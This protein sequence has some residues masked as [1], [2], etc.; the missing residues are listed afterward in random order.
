VLEVGKQIQKV[1]NALLTI[2]E[3]WEP[4][5]RAQFAR[6][7]MDQVL[8]AVLFPADARL[9][10]QMFV[11]TNLYGKRLDQLALLKGMIGDLAETQEQADAVVV[12][13]TSIQDRLGR[14]FESFMRAIDV[15]ERVELNARGGVEPQQDNWCVELGTHLE[16]HY[17]QGKIV[18]WMEWLRDY[19]Y[20]WDDLQ[21]VLI[22]GGE[23]EL[24]QNTFRL[25]AF[26]T[27]DWQSLALFYWREIREDKALGRF[28]IEKQ[29][30]YAKLFGRLHRSCMALTLG[31]SVA[32]RQQAFA[33]SVWQAK[34]GLDPTVTVNRKPGELV[35][36][37]KTKLKIDRELQ[38]Q[39]K[40]DDVWVPLVRWL[41]MAR[42]R[43]GLPGLMQ[44]GSVEHIK[45]R[46]PPPEELAG[47]PHYDNDCYSLGNLAL[48]NSAVNM[49]LD[50]KSYEQKVHAL[51]SEAQR[52][53]LI[54]SVVQEAH[55]GSAE[56]TKRASLLRDKVWELL[57][58]PPRPGARRPRTGT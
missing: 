39:I 43:P 19:S 36:F 52:Y 22:E 13:W 56:I 4:L 50:N 28:S 42:W 44:N 5:R 3:R 38:S 24:E 37:A 31:G 25:S 57:D 26:Q 40:S 55:W 27:S 9:G 12:L 32:G 2:F 35:I 15:I 47:E 20:A 51:K 10:R 16:R 18:G 7:L 49:R 46:N 29:R 34:C 17:R 1:K 33:K 41:E 45:P 58:M 30:D 14:D 11:S 48:I 54:G 21:R 53:D 8:V 6:F 23:S